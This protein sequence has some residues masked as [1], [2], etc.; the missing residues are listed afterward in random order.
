MVYLGSG[1]RRF[2]LQTVFLTSF[3]HCL[4]SVWIYFMAVFLSSLIGNYKSLRGLWSALLPSTVF[5]YR[6]C[7]FQLIWAPSQQRQERA[8][9]LWFWCP[10][11]GNKQFKC[12]ITWHS[13]F[14]WHVT[15]ST[16]IWTSNHFIFW[17]INKQV[18]QI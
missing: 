1:P 16:L 17:N 4:S 18:T 5:P 14:S 7:T 13:F 9:P 15:V 12:E 2:N 8:L 11:L 6:L 3:P 10:L